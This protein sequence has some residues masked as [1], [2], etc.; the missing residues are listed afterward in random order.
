MTGIQLKV[1][2]TKGKCIGS[3][4]WEIEGKGTLGIRGHRT[5]NHVHLG[6]QV[7]QLHPEQW[8]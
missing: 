6:Y 1:A 7:V 8:E 3:Y 2:Y 5:R 4:N